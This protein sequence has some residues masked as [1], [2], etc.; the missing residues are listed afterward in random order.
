MSGGYKKTE[1]NGKRK[2]VEIAA[3]GDSAWK[4]KTYN[5][6]AGYIEKRKHMSIFMTDLGKIKD[7]ILKELIIA[8]KK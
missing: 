8:M 5:E 7:I 2:S 6:V 1:S 3:G 4:P